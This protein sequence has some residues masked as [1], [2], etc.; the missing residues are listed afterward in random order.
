MSSPRPRRFYGDVTVE[1]G[2]DGY[3]VLLDGKAIRTPARA[4]FAVP[5]RPLAEAIAEEWRA[6]DGHIAAPSMPLLR[7]T[8]SALERVPAARDA[9][10]GQLLDYARNDLLCYH[11]EGPALLTARQSEQWQPLLDWLKSAGGIALTTTRGIV[12]VAQSEASIAALQQRLAALDDFSLTGVSAAAALTGSV[13]L[14]LALNAGRIGSTEAF[15]LAT[16]DER[17]QAEHWGRD[18]EAQARLDHMAR[19]LA[20]VV[21]FLR[22]AA[23]TTP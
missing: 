19:E 7:L 15:D 14:A 20:A 22:L 16:L 17:F 3:A 8:N 21:R 12:H 13:V 18:A 10:V 1:A 11:A 6:Q 23:S 2:V 4:V 5:S 9:V